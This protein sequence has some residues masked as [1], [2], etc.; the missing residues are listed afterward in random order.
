LHA[1]AIWKKDKKSFFGK[2]TCASCRKTSDNEK[3]NYITNEIKQ[4]C[5]QLFEWLYNFD[6]VHT[7]TTIS[8]KSDTTS[9]SPTIYSGAARDD[10]EVLKNFLRSMNYKYEI[11][12]TFSY[13]ARSSKSKENFCRFTKHILQF[14]VQ[15]V[16]PNDSNQVWSDIVEAAADSSNVSNIHM[17]KDF[18]IVMRGLAESYENCDHWSTRQQI[19]S[20]FAKEVS[21]PVIQKFIPDLTDWRFKQARAHADSAGKG[22][23]VDTSRQPTVRYRDEQIAHFVQFITSPH[24]STDLPFKQKTLKLS[25]GEEI[26]IPNVIR[27]L[28]P[29]RIIDQYILYCTEMSPGFVPLG[30]SSLYSIL[31]ECSASTRKSLQ[32]LDYFAA[33]GSSSFDTLMKLTDELLH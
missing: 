26:E 28:I 9:Y 4:Q 7:P 22:S 17:G 21:L 31:S 20:T 24:V 33:D 1:F 18:E 13:N 10:Q 8:S 16:A 6:V 14:I 27:N 30:T 29:T 32:G 15:I 3:N 23:V 2:V 25:T 12:V 5:D 11:P 19:L